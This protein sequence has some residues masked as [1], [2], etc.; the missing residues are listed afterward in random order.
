MPRSRIEVLLNYEEKMY[1]SEDLRTVSIRDL[2]LVSALVTLGF[3][4]EDTTKDVNGR[5]HFIFQ[6]TA[7]LNEA[8]NGYY[9]DTL[10]VKARRFFDNAKMLKSRIHEA[11]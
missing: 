2:G 11:N 7:A 4:I 1:M 10:H 3:E 6:Q 9:A 8:T 5:M